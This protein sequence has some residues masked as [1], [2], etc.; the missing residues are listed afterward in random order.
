MKH[1]NL[2][3]LLGELDACSLVVEW[4][5]SKSIEEVVDKCH[6]GDW[7]L[8][9]AN[10]VKV[11]DRKLTLA[12]GYCANTVIHL[13]ISSKSRKAVKTAIRYGRY[14]ASKEDLIAAH[15]DAA[16]AA[17]SAAAA[18]DAVYD[19]AYDDAADAARYSAA[20]A[21]RSA[22]AV[23]D[24]AYDDAAAAAYDDAYDDAAAAA[25]DAAAVDAEKHNQMST[26]DICRKYIGKEI[27]RAVNIKLNK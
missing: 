8:W 25:Y 16:A 1:E 18:Y 24:D 6:R 20:A 5:E 26:A 11:N 17:R 27:I 7:L 10:R 21:A 19:D 3:Q 14:K 9:L 2:N 23:Y 4:V 22:A 15:N 13:M 12:K